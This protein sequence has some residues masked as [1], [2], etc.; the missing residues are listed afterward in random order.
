MGEMKK[1]H[2]VFANNQT[3]KVEH[4][5]VFVAQ[6]QRRLWWLKIVY[7]ILNQLRADTIES[8]SCVHTEYAHHVH[9][10]RAINRYLWYNPSEM[11]WTFDHTNLKKSSNELWLIIQV[12]F[13]K[14]L[15]ISQVEIFTLTQSLYEC[16]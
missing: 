15:H 7:N 16:L 1:K 9:L 8:D 2:F 14:S 3:E 6:R 12:F 10:I 11:K 13:L 4:A 5:T